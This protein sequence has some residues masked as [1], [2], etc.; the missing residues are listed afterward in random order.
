MKSS[1]EEVRVYKECDSDIPHELFPEVYVN[2]L[3]KPDLAAAVA[4]VYG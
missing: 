1:Q 3:R 2:A 4:E